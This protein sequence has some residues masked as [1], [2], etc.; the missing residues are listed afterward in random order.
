MSVPATILFATGNPNKLREIRAILSAVGSGAG[1]GVHGLDT[2]GKDVAEPEETGQTFIANALLKARYYAEA[3]GELTLAEDSGLE[4]DAL[5]GE[6]GVRSARYSGVAG[7]RETVDAANNQR[8][9]EKLEGVAEADRTAR[10]VCAMALCEADRTWAVVRG[11]LEGR[12]LQ[13]P[14]GA[15]GFGYDP[16]FF[17]PS[18][19][20]TTAELSAEQKNAISHRGSATRAM[21]E[22]LQLLMS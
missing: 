11:T 21:A 14:R 20:A 19:Q 9:L 2:L 3:A 8:L 5:Q 13:Q 1:P 4:V 16:L 6:P 7:E 17:V 22:V 12:I 15:G 18:Q 10:F